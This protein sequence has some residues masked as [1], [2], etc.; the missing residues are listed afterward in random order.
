MPNTNDKRPL[1]G[2]SD[3]NTKWDQSLREG[4]KALANSE[5]ITKY[6]CGCIW[7][8]PKS[9]R[10]PV[11]HRRKKVEYR[12]CGELGCT[13][14]WKIEK[15]KNRQFCS[16]HAEERRKARQAEVNDRYS[17]DSIAADGSKVVETGLSHI[18]LDEAAKRIGLSDEGCRKVEIRALK[19]FVDRFRELNPELLEE[20]G[21]RMNF[22]M[23]SHLVEMADDK[24]RTAQYN[25]EFFVLWGLTVYAAS[26]GYPWAVDW[27][28]LPPDERSDKLL[29]FKTQKESELVR[30]KAIKS[31][32]ALPQEVRAIETS[33]LRQDYKERYDLEYFLSGIA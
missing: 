30:S 31:G 7:I 19:K 9:T 11:H 22:P 24:L 26:W 21:N 33:R 8:N 12:R 14:I 17:L 3:Y 23:I 27:P 32:I 5:R 29:F 6:H 2:G 16:Y 28:E 13:E 15:A 10:C 4:I 18:L 20:A 1:G 25:G